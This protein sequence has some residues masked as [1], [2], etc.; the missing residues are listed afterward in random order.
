MGIAVNS[1]QQM[2]NL[3]PLKK[4]IITAAILLPLVILGILFLPLSVFMVVSGMIFLLALWEWTALAGFQSIVGRVFCCVLIALFAFSVLVILQWFGPSFVKEGVPLLIMGFWILAL[5][6]ICLYPKYLLVWQSKATGVVAGG[7]VLIP[8]WGMLIAL[9]DLD[10]Q[11]ILYVLSL[12]WVS[13]TTAYFVGKRFGQ[14]KLAPHISPA[15]TWEG[16]W[17]AMLAT[18]VVAGFFYPTLELQLSWLGWIVLSLI[19]TVF[20]IVGDLFESTFKRIRHLKDSGSLLPGH[21]GILDRIDS[22]TAAVPIFTVN[23]MLF[24]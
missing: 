1:L 2:Q 6:L 4:R 12:V 24:G 5:S 13:D 9:Q 14:H 11:W 16:V 10:P 3:S 7:M 8:A 15:K 20:S 21:G 23:L 22:L 17:G 18:L 19:T